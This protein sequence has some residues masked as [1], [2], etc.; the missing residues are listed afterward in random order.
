M[1]IKQ[2][3]GIFGRNPT[4]NDVTV[5]GTLDANALSVDS[6]IATTGNISTTATV[7]AAKVEV[8][9][10]DVAVELRS[11]NTFGSALN[12][13]RF[14]DWDGSAQAGQEIGKIEFYSSDASAPGA[15]V[16]AY[17]AGVTEVGNPGGGL[18]F[19]TDLL[20]GTPTEAFRVDRFKNVS[21]VNG[22]GS[23]IL[24]NGAGI[25]FSATSG[26][27]TSELFDDYEEG[28]CTVT[29]TPASGSITLA[30]NTL[31]YTKIG[32]Q[33]TVLGRI[34]ASA[35][36]SPS[37]GLTLA[38]LPFTVNASMIGAV[39]IYATGMSSAPSGNIMA[40]SWLGSNT[41]INFSV[42][43]NQITASTYLRFEFSYFV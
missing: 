3:G 35:V 36:S 5:D 42:D 9:S 43:A 2:Q 34:N 28:T 18:V 37:G 39:S 26:T 8:T 10:T 38:G 15:G 13:L 22:G 24:A 14:T 20:T 33:V 41:V 23:V 4:F 16:K 25:D 30:A 40:D 7:E 6:T 11:N 31:N 19:G 1:T 32:R 29:L 21:L 27:G 12:K 17:I